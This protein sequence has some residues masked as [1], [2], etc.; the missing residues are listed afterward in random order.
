MLIP[1]RISRDLNRLGRLKM[2][3]G[4]GDWA[5]IEAPDFIADAILSRLPSE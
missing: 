3:E 5:A 4:V 2:R 1:I